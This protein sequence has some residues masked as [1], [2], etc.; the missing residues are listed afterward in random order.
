MTRV[1]IVTGASRGIGLA[2]AE[3]LVGLGWRV[4]G[5]SRGTSDFESP[6]YRHHEVDVAD[7]DAVRGMVR[8]AGAEGLDLL[9]NNAGT[10]SMNLAV[11]ATT[12]SVRRI[13][14]TNFLGTFLFC[15]EAARVMLR[16]RRGRIVNVVSVA[17]P[18]SLEGEAAYAASKAAVASFTRTFSRE[19]A[20]HGI[21]VN[22]VGPGPIMTDLIAG[23]GKE[24]IDALVNRRQ[25]IHRLGRV[26]DVLNVVDFFASD[27]SDFVTGQVIYLGGVT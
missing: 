25:S 20:A 9:L 8:E 14:E 22:A 11:L 7:E 17:D 6:L 3:H 15:R 16:R 27:R 12:S 19:V 13:M 10:A 1:A 24:R 2:A 23:V 5:C 4:H 26:D 18:L 21:T